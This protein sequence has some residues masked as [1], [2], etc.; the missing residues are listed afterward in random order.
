MYE[1]LIEFYNKKKFSIKR[2]LNDTPEAIEIRQLTSFLDD[3]GLFSNINYKQRIWHIINNQLSLKLCIICNKPVHWDNGNHRYPETC[4]CK[5]CKSQY[6]ASD[7]VVQKRVQ[8]NLKKYGVKHL[9]QTKEWKDNLKRHNLETYGVVGYT[10]TEEFKEKSR[11]TCLE[12]YGT[13]YY[14]SSGI[15]KDNY[16]EMLEKYKTYLFGEIWNRIYIQT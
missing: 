3:S 1:H 8:T 6:A 15:F 14:P 5:E 12:K 2:Y 4:N 13:E 10:Q 9:Q 11:R 7:I 16:P